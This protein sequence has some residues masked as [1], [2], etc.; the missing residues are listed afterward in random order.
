MVQNIS[1]PASLARKWFVRS[2]FLVSVWFFRQ[3]IRLERSNLKRP[4]TSLEPNLESIDW[5]GGNEQLEHG[6]KSNLREKNHGGFTGYYLLSH[7]YFGPTLV[8]VFSETVLHIDFLL[9]SM[10][11]S[12]FKGSQ[13]YKHAES[14]AECEQRKY[15]KEFC[16]RHLLPERT[17]IACHVVACEA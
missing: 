13:Y 15:E 9:L 7:F 6:S 1:N 3:L 14:R 16:L 4:E 11:Y 2:L 8:P 12:S 10:P 5:K 17:E